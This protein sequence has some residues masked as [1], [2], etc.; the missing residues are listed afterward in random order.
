MALQRRRRVEKLGLPEFIG[1]VLLAVTVACT[2]LWWHGRHEIEWRTAGGRVLRCEVRPNQYRAQDVPYNVDLSY[3]YTVGGRQFS[4]QWRGVW[5]QFVSPNALP[6]SRL[7][8]LL[9]KD[10]PLVVLYD[11]NDAAR[12]TLHGAPIW[13][14]RASG[15]AVAAVLIVLLVYGVRVYPGWKTRQ[16]HRLIRG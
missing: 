8:E 2:F 14:R 6:T 5:P 7:S 9:R 4:G 13:A 16:S 3:E 11:P 12:S 15:A 1:V 10:Y